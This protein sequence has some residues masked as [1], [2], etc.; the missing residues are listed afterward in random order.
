MGRKWAQMLTSVLSAA[1][2][3]SLT[4]CGETTSNATIESINPST[5]GQQSAQPT[6]ELENPTQMT[7]DPE[8]IEETIEE[9]AKKAMETLEVWDGSIAESF[10]GGDG[11]AENP[12]QIAN[13]AQLAK[14]ARDTNNGVDFSASHFVLTSDIL[15]NDISPW[16]FDQKAYYGSIDTYNNW[17]PIGLNYFFGGIFDGRD[18]IIYGLYNSLAYRNTFYNKVGGNIGLFG[19]LKN[20]VVSNLSVACGIFTSTA[21][22]VGSIVGQIEKGSVNNCHAVQ[23]DITLGYADKVG[24]ICGSFTNNNGIDVTNCSFEGRIAC[25]NI[26]QKTIA[27]GGIVGSGVAYENSGLVSRCYSKCNL[28]ILDAEIIPPEGE[29]YTSHIYVGGICG[30]G[31]VI[32]SCYSTS[33]I[34]VSADAPISGNLEGDLSVSIGGIAGHCNTSITNCGSSGRSEYSGNIENIYVG[35]IA[36]ILGNNERPRD[37]WFGHWYQAAATFC[38]SDVAMEINNTTGTKNAGGISGCA[39]GEITVTNCYYNNE[40]SDRAVAH[41]VPQSAVFTDQIKGLSDDELCEGSNY[42][43]WDFDFM[44]MTDDKLNNGLPMLQSLIGYY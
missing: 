2:I 37:D 8:I 19:T 1:L 21:E 25:N 18:Y 26:T 12:Y 39:G 4:A 22:N 6:D 27:M 44:W 17:E 7:Q 11:S 31:N 32:S 33:N 34:V 5:S 3:I 20:G 29:S 10:D 40:Y 23:M 13:G 30:I 42:Y 35:G 43:N 14:L 38:Y 36:G 41:T 9:K 15:L 16:D 24:G 28:S